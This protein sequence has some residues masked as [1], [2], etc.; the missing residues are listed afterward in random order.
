[1]YS[2]FAFIESGDCTICS[3]IF[4][5][6][7]IVMLLYQFTNRYFPIFLEINIHI[8][9]L[10]V[11]MWWLRKASRFCQLLAHVSTV[12]HGSTGR[13]FR[14]HPRDQ[15]RKCIEDVGMGSKFVTDTQNHLN[16]G[17]WIHVLNGG[18]QGYTPYISYNNIFVFLVSHACG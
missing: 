17:W 12:H 11:C 9:F 7:T 4:H 13:K 3:C 18:F 14:H 2:C 1:M 10:R 16:I 6:E 8:S 5:V 15:A